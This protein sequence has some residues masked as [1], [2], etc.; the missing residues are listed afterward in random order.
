MCGKELL[1]FGGEPTSIYKILIIDLDE[2]YCAD[3]YSDLEIKKLF[4]CHS[5]VP[6]KH[7]KGG[8]S[9]ARF[10]RIRENQITL[11]FK[12]INEYLKQLDGDNLY[13]G[14]SFVYKERFLSNLSTYNRN[15]IKDISKSEYGGLTGIYQYIKKLEN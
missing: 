14:I 13:V 7:K 15:K 9:A 11:W 3:I 1:K 4:Q 8:Q 6:H 2:C 10:G 12:R 5:D